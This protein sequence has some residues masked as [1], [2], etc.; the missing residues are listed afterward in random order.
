MERSKKLTIE[1]AVQLIK[2]GDRIMIGGFGNIGAPKLL[3]DALAKRDV[4]DLTIISNDLGDPGVGL[5]RLLLDGKIKR[6]IGT[7]Y[8][9]NRDVAT[10]RNAG[11]IEVKLVPQGSF[12]EAI[13]AAGVGVAGFYTRTGIGTAIAEGKETKDFDGKTYLLEESISADVALI[14]AEMSDELGNL[15][16][17][18]TTRNFNPLMAMAAKTVIAEVNKIL[19]IG[20]LDPDEIVTPHI[21]VNFIVSREG[22]M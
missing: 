22:T 13:R 11:K 19:P 12:A 14:C 18:K 9:W 1:E 5:G 10:T 8:T 7:Y 4:R 16:F 3:I 2:D 20:A 21:F 15:V 17:Y 6:L